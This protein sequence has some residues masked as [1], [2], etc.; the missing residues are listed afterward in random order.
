[1]RYIQKQEE[2]AE[3]LE[4]KRKFKNKNNRNANYDDITKDKKAV[5][6][7]MTA[8]DI[9]KRELIREQRGICCYC[10]NS[11]SQRNSHI[12]HFRPKGRAEYKNLTLAYENLHA[13]C[14]GIY[15]SKETCGHNKHG[16]FDEN[17]MIS[18]LDK[19]CGEEFTYNEFGEITP[20]QE[21]DR[22]KYTIEV[23]HLDDERLTKAREIAIFN[24]GILDIENEEERQLFY[25]EF[26]LPDQNGNLA[27]FCDAILYLITH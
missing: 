27:P 6:G 12:E 5:Q 26:N 10:C 25:D 7:N 11:I 19:N 20:F 8:K 17:L 2:P 14:Q 16:D 13:S 18:P 15:D 4:W 24:S 9:L 3:V 23:L 1:M 22:A 21:R